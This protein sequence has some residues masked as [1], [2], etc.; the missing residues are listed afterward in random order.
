MSAE[1]VGFDQQSFFNWHIFVD[2]FLGSTLY[3]EVAEFERV[4]FA[5]KDFDGV[6]S[7]VHQV[8]L[9]DYAYGAVA[10]WVYFASKLE[11]VAVGEVCVGWC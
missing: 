2:L 4:Q 9:G 7:F 10:F 11:R 5:L 8:D 6:C 3:A 1:E